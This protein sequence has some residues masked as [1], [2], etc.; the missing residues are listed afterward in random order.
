MSNSYM[1]LTFQWYSRGIKTIK[2]D[3]NITLRQLINAI[4]TPKPE[5]IEAFKLIQEAG[6][7]K[8]KA[9]KD[10]LKAEK[11]FFT[12][13]SAIFDPIRNYDSIKNFLP[14][15]VYEYDDIE[16][17]EELRD[18]IFEKRKDCI[19]AFCSPSFTGTKFIFLFGETPTSIEHYKQL[20]FGIAHDLDKFKN[21]DMSNERCTQPLYNSYDPNARFREDAVGSV[22]RGYKENSFVPFVG[23]IEIPEEVSEED[24]EKCFSLITHLI[25]RITDSGH[26]QIV[27]ATFTASGLCA[28]YGINTDEMWDLIEDRIR[29]NAYLAKG[30]DGY[31]KTAQTMFNKGLNFPTALKKKDNE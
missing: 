6:A 3:G 21:L 23:E 7:K 18:Y 13:P 25:D 20:W 14:L 27:S 30:T 19:F 4:I 16:H 15:G 10:R 2:P 31:L 29:S 5:M 26:N 11:L 1:D 22:V 8:D 17:C 12:T 9:E 24:V 28:F